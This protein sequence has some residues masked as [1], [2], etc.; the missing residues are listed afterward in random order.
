MFKYILVIISIIG[1]ITISGCS[2]FGTTTPTVAPTPTEVIVNTNPIDYDPLQ[3]DQGSY[4]SGRPANA[5]STEHWI[6]PA[7]YNTTN[8][9]AGYTAKFTI[10]IHNGNPYS[11][12][13][14]VL[15][16]HPDNVDVGFAAATYSVK[17]WVK[18]SEEYPVIEA[19]GT[20]EIVVTLSMPEG[21]IA[22]ANQWLFWVCAKDISQDAMI[23][24]RL[25]LKFKVTMQ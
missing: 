4:D 23:Q 8:Y 19:F 15:Y 20:R 3:P 1:V 2:L 17:D 13:F 16:T 6:S 18:I 12:P 5:P 21:A 9:R 7:T 10:R 24:T 14:S 11:T 25:C 22:P